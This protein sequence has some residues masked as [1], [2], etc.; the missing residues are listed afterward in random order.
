MIAKAG[1]AVL[2]VGYVL[3][4]CASFAF[5]QTQTTGRIA[6]TVKDERGALVVGAEVTVTSKTTAGERRVITDSV[7][8]YT[9]PLLA[10]GAYD[11]R[12]TAR[13]FAT[14]VFD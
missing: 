3:A 9:V 1:F 11:V 2:S 4:L 13:G 14:S 7:A 10:P 6:G 12:I 8:T 5:G